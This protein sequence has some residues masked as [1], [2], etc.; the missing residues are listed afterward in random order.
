VT[1]LKMPLEPY[2]DAAVKY[3]DENAKSFDEIRIAVA[4]LERLARPAPRAKAWLQ[5]VEK[6]WNADGTAGKGDG[7]ARA[8]GSAAVTVLRLGAPLKARERVLKVLKDGQRRDGGYGKEAPGSDLETT[9]RV[10]RA[11]VMLKER[12]GDVEGLRAFVE[13]CRNKD[14]G[15]GIAPGTP[16]AVGSTYYAAIIHHWLEAK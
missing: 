12:P 11:F 6:Q 9:Y 2:A 10:L 7:A 16:S 3:L 5:E 4:G 1:E 15:Y 8:T 13:R 14:G